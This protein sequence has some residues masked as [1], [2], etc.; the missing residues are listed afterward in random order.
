[1]SQSIKVAGLSNI[2]GVILL[3]YI[4][5]DDNYNTALAKNKGQK[6]TELL[7]CFFLLFRRVAKGDYRRSTA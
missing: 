1:M 6:S 7:V 2:H 4:L 5:S 3:A